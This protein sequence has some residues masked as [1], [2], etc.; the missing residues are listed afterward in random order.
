MPTKFE[1]DVYHNGG[2]VRSI[3]FDEDDV[4]MNAADYPNCLAQGSLLL[5][6]YWLVN[7]WN[8]LGLLQGYTYILKTDK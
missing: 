2:Y 1:I 6:T 4:L 7:H 5:M 8:R 3:T